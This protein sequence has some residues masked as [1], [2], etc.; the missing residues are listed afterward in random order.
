MSPGRIAELLSRTGLV[1]DARLIREP[2]EQEKPRQGRHL[3]ARKPG[4]SVGDL[5]TR[6]AGNV[7]WDESAD[8]IPGD[9]I[10]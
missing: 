2:N 5:E 9:N 10:K 6:A 3:V 4:K 8:P 1:V 7:S